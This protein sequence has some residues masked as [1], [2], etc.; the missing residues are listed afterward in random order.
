VVLGDERAHVPMVLQQR[1]QPERRL[2]ALLDGSTGLVFE[3]L[4]RGVHRAVDV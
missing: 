2:D 1:F 4:A 3:R